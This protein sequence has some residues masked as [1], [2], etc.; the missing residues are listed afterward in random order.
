MFVSVL[1]QVAIAWVYSHII[2]YCLHRWWLHDYKRKHW[3][4]DHFGNHHKAAKKNQMY[5][6]R[7]H[8]KIDP[9]GD[10]EI[11]GLGLLALMHCPVA[12]W[13]PWAYLVLV[14]SAITYFFVHRRSHQDYRWAREN[15]PWHYDHHMGPDQHMNWGVRLPWVDWFVGTRAIH[16]GT[17]RE[18]K[19]YNNFLK[20][21]KRIYAIRSYRD[22][23]KKYQKSDG[24]VR[25]Q[26]WSAD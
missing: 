4:K 18:E 20:T 11:K 9:I 10:R 15:V 6:A 26:P 25:K 7:Y 2:E 14:Y 12:F 21:I 3:F 22:K 23:R 17:P 16:V 1:L 5:D 8:S 24:M 13:F 19:E